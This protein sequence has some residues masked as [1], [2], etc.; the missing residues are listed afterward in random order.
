MNHEWDFV[1]DVKSNQDIAQEIADETKIKFIT[2]FLPHPPKISLLLLLP[3]LF[4]SSTLLQSIVLEL[5][6]VGIPV[7]RERA[8]LVDSPFI[9]FE[10]F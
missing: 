5:K 7:Y 9:Y 1:R 8:Y 6:I 10:Y 3:L 4:P 2:Y